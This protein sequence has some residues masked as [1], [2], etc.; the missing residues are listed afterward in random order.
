MDELGVWYRLDGVRARFGDAFELLEDAR[1]EPGAWSS[2]EG[3]PLLELEGLCG[4]LE[5]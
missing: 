4:G 2:R 1:C 3:L 5:S